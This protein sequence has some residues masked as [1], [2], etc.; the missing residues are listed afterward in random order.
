MRSLGLGELSLTKLGHTGA[1]G[2]RDRPKRAVGQTLEELKAGIMAD[3]ERLADVIDL[4]ALV[5]RAANKRPN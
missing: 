3:L 4:E 5:A 2:G 1:V